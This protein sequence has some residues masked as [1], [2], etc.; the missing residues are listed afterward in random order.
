M[1]TSPTISFQFKIDAD[2]KTYSAAVMMSTRSRITHQF[3]HKLKQSCLNAIN[4]YRLKV[5]AP[6][7]TS[8]DINTGTFNWINV[9]DY[10]YT[11]TLYIDARQATDFTHVFWYVNHDTNTFYCDAETVNHRAIKR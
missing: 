11:F 9:D 10:K 7:A 6:F 1:E 3:V 4:T 5:G 2:P 8:V